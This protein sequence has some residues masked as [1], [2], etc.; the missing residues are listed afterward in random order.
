MMSSEILFQ[1]IVNALLLSM[2]YMAVAIGI[3]LIF[4]I[5]NLLSFVHGELYMLGGYGV[6]LIYQ[7]FG[8]PYWLAIIVSAASVAL[9]GVLLERTV[10]TLTSRTGPSDATRSRHEMR[11]I[12]R[13]MR[14]GPSFRVSRIT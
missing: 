2:I 13:G 5:M 4:S 10:T 11:W 14:S 9:I 12:R 1:T 8:Y 3:T 6:Y 7:R